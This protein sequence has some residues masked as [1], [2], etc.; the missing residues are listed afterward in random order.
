MEDG[1]NPL[2]DSYANF[3]VVVRVELKGMVT[4]GKWGSNRMLSVSLHLSSAGTF[5]P[6]AFF[7]EKMECFV[8]ILSGRDSQ[9]YRSIGAYADGK[10]T[11]SS[12]VV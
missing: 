5:D 4:C 6:I 2:T 9:T 8:E 3:S 12:R 10:T 11:G 7:I 1:D